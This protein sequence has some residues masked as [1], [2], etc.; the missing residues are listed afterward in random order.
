LGNIQRYLSAGLS[1][2]A[3]IAALP[4]CAKAQDKSFLPDDPLWNAPAPINV[5]ANLP[6]RQTD[7]EY[8]F[9]YFNFVNRPT[10]TGLPARGVN[11][12]GEVPDSE[13][14]TNRHY[15]KRMSLDELRRGPGNTTPPVCPC[16]A[17]A[18]K[19]EG[20]NPGFTIRDSK[21]EKYFLKFDPPSNP[22]LAT[23][24]D[25]V[26]S[27][28]FYA[29]GYFT[30]ENYIAY[31]TQDDFAIASDATFI[32]KNGK[33]RRMHRSDLDRVLQL[34]QP[35]KDGKIR[36]LASR[37]VPGRTIGPYRL[38]R[39]RMDDPN[40]YI[41][42][43][44]RRDQ[45]GLFVFS[46][47][48]NHTDIKGPNTMDTLVE[49]GGVRYVRHYLID[50]GAMLGSDSYMA[51]DARNGFEYALP[52]N[53]EEP[54]LTIA[55]LGLWIR[56]WEKAD[57][58]SYKSL[59]RFSGDPFEPDEW[60]PTYGNHAFE[61]RLPDD[62]FW[63]AKQVMH[64]T[65]EEIRA[66]V[67]TGEYSDP[68]VSDYLTNALIIRRDKIGRTY[69]S[70]LLPLDNFRLENNQLIFDDLSV[71]YR[72]GMTRKY[73]YSWFAFDN[74][75]AVRIPVASASGPE[76][77][78]TGSLYF[79]AQI[80]AVDDDSKSVTVFLRKREVVGIQRSF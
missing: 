46:A 7:R 11:T 32:G 73:K 31:L 59:G 62:E 75:R 1:Q 58:P 79:G 29:M 53:P 6:Y 54:L 14:Y 51:K 20:I 9:V 48:L 45:R 35:G 49:E 78:D 60:R 25:V 68:R 71:R 36:F 38:L 27:K 43:E 42:H 19:T 76:I 80:A 57:Y 47:W 30:P 72:L 67:E 77:P 65:N 52:D 44:N 12:L 37:S 64:C 4:I 2:L 28:F 41:R 21:N 18:G 26:G 69:F 13:W 15:R 70:K 8:D 10:A 39:T 50:F 23:A 17:V 40:D 66:M 33:E 22:E 63:A 34:A 16:K 24:A 56:P 55:S 74:D 5:A 3:L 61:S